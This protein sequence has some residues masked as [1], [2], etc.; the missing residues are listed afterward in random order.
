ML[1]HALVHALVPATDHREAFVL[2][3]LA[4][5]FLDWL[6]TES[7]QRFFAYLHYME[8]HWPYSEGIAHL[9]RFGFAVAVH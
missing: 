1:A 9:D 2:G 7:P 5:E 4:G 3:E 6:D 8:P